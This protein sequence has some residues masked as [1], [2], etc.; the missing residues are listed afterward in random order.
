MKGKAFPTLTTLIT[1]VNCVLSYEKYFLT[2]PDETLKD[3]QS[4]E[5][6]LRK[7]K[8]RLEKVAMFFNSFMDSFTIN[9]DSSLLKNNVS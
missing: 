4:V 8:L 5:V 9:V 3:G 6:I 2:G 7:R 1:I